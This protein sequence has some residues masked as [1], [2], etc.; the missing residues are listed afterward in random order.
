MACTN[1]TANELDAVFQA[2]GDFIV[3]LDYGAY[4]N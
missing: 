3:K 4:M 1:D 2:G